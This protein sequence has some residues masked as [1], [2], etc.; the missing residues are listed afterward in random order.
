MTWALLPP[1]KAFR[2]AMLWKR[3]RKIMAEFEQAQKGIE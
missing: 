2:Y 1:I 3:A